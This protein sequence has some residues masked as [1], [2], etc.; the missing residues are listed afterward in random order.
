MLCCNFSAITTDSFLLF[1]LMDKA[2]L[3]YVY[4]NKKPSLEFKKLE[5]LSAL[6]PKVHRKL[7]ID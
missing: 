3:C 7:F 2:K 4:F 1:S 5:K 6:E